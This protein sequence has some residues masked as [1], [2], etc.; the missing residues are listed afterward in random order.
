MKETRHYPSSCLSIFCSRTECPASC[1][2]LSKL[3]AFKA[4][5]KKTGAKVEDRIWSPTL[6][7]A[8]K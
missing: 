1:P 6:Y 3:A 4:W 7:T 5:V 8:Q 2:S